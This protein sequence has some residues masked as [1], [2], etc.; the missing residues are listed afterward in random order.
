MPFLTKLQIESVRGKNSYKL[1]SPLVYQFGS[2]IFA[3]KK[4]FVTDF[5]SIPRLLRFL[6]DDDDADIREAAVIHDWL[7]S[8]K[9]VSRK[10]ADCVLMTAMKDIG[11]SYIKRKV[12]YLAVRFF[13]S[14]HYE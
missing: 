8:T 7:Y 12:V 5:A 3:A 1:L 14:N 11:A 4:G 2:S 13:G 9:E 10:F 6:I